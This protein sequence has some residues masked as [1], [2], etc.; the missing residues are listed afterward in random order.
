[1]S[2]K[3]GFGLIDAKDS[4]VIDID[5]NI[6]LNIHNAAVMGEAEAEYLNRL[7]KLQEEI[8]NKY[9]PN[10]IANKPVEGEPAGWDKGNPMDV[11]EEVREKLLHKNTGHL[12]YS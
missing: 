1:M 11:N 7:L 4:E 8:I 5:G 10:L 6:P 12:W 9:G 2:D 3:I